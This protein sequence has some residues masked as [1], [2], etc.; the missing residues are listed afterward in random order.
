MCIN[1]GG[2]SFDRRTYDPVAEKHFIRKEDLAD[3]QYAAGGQSIY[4]DNNTAGGLSGGR[5]FRN[6]QYSSNGK[7]QNNEV[8]QY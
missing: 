4:N 2:Q 7:G 6:S 5:Q 1:V 8:I 3:A